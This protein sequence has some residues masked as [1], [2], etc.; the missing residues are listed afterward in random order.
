MPEYSFK[1]PKTKEIKTLIQKMSDKHEFVDDNG[2][3]WERVFEVPNAS[4]D[5]EIDPFSLQ[6][7][8]EKT[9]N[10]RGNVGNLWD[11]SKEL[12]EKRIKLSGKDKV[13]EKTIQ[14]YRKKCKGKRHPH[15]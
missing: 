5:T 3:R 4:I 7:F 15:E 14:D 2:V 9:N 10:K 12:S 13:K 11:L 6:D 1:H 8:K